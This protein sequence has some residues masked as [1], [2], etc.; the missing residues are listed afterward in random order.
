M[1]EHLVGE[2]SFV[3]LTFSSCNS[4]TDTPPFTYHPFNGPGMCAVYNFQRLIFGNSP[5]PG[6]FTGKP[7]KSRFT[8][9]FILCTIYKVNVVA[10]YLE[11]CSPT[12]DNNVIIAALLQHQEDNFS[13]PTGKNR[14]KIDRNKSVS[15]KW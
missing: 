3:Q 4:P 13:K 5:S 9:T 12:T 1:Q 11:M 10:Q 6:K 8:L 15:K 14:S 7:K 2:F